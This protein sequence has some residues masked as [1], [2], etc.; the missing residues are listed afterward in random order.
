MNR[1][2]T[3]ADRT[4]PPTTICNAAKPLKPSSRATRKGIA[5]VDEP[6]LHPAL[7]PARAL[8]DPRLHARRRFLIGGRAND[9]RAVSESRKP[10]AE[11]GILGDIEGV[12][13]AGIAQ[14]LR[15]KMV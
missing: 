11:V 7:E 1:G 13:P 15:A 14:R 9:G 4:V 6:G 2:C 12:P 5:H 8:P 10:H 3:N